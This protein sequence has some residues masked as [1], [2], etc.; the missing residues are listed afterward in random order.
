MRKIC[1]IGL[2]IFIFCGLSFLLYP[3][4]KKLYL[5]LSSSGSVSGWEQFA[6]N[7]DTTDFGIVQGAVAD[8]NNSAGIASLPESGEEETQEQKNVDAVAVDMYFVYEATT[9]VLPSEVVKRFVRGDCTASESD[10]L[11]V[12]PCVNVGE[13]QSYVEER[14]QSM[15]GGSQTML[16]AKNENGAYFYRDV[17]WSVDTGELVNQ[18]VNSLAERAQEYRNR[19]CRPETEYEALYGANDRNPVIWVRKMETAGTDGQYAPFY[20]EID[21]SQQHLYL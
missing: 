20:I 16:E 14:L 6:Q 12:I 9:I 5:S 7:A 1:L 8:K 19:S 4:G 13:I 3:E 15:L 2:G 18:I 21:D 17:D 11:S 10:C